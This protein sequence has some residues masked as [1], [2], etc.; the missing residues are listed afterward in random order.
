MDKTIKANS[1]SW[2]HYQT[3]PRRASRIINLGT[4]FFRAAQIVVRARVYANLYLAVHLLTTKKCLRVEG[5]LM[6]YSTH[7]QPSLGNRT[8]FTE[9]EDQT[10][11][12]PIQNQ[13][14]RQLCL[15]VMNMAGPSQDFFV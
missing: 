14:T 13:K 4:R 6:V 12:L 11:L 2:S 9:K 15:K 7:H 8:F 10:C 3:S 5:K 1:K